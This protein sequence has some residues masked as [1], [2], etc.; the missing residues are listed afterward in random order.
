M[1]NLMIGTNMADLTY[2]YLPI[3]EAIV[4]KDART[5]YREAW[6][7]RRIMFQHARDN[8]SYAKWHEHFVNIKHSSDLGAKCVHQIEDVAWR[9]LGTF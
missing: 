8:Y 1:K 7:V 5:L 2:H 4:A 9:V 6:R 3:A